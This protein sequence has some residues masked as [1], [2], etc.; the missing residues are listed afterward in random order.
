VQGASKGSAV[1]KIRFSE[2]GSSSARAAMPAVDDVVRD[3]FPSF[4]HRIV[5]LSE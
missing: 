5:R 1:K 4:L 3:R 2:G